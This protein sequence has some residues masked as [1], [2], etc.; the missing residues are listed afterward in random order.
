[1]SNIGSKK[2][3]HKQQVWLYV[4][5]VLFC[6]DFVFYGYMPS[7]KRLRSLREAE[8]QQERMIQM[9][10]AQGEELPS[11]RTRL[12]NTQ[13][14]VAHYDSYVPQDASQAV[15]L[16]EIA[17]VMTGHSL[18]DQVVVPGKEADSGGIR[19][20]SVRVNCKGSLKDIFGLFHDLQGMDR[21][22]R[23]ERV[24]LQN[25]RDFTGQVSMETE[26][27]IFYQP[28]VERDGTTVAAGQ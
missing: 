9:A 7:H 2:Q 28:Q 24:L 1:M 23:I 14:I 27:V 11:L 25:D 17:R 10:A 18:T 12:K 3:G 22:V 20:I 5:G 16:Q 19:C 4:V 6:A 13:E 21:L 26:A 8:V 15:F